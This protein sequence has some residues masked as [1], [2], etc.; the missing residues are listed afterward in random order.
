MSSSKGSGAVR[1]PLAIWAANDACPPSPGCTLND[2]PMWEE[3]ATESGVYA[4]VWQYAQSPRRAKISKGCPQNQ[5]PDGMCYVPGLP[6]STSTF[7]DLDTA[8]S[9]DPSEAP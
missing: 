5:A 9:P 1:E 7:V 3:F 4:A 6:H 8:D 2:R